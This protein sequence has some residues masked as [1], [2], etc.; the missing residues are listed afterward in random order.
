LPYNY[1]LNLNYTKRTKTIAF[2]D[3]LII[4][5]RGKTVKKA[6]NSKH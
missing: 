6:E 1:I 5:I 2:A 3:D 4:V